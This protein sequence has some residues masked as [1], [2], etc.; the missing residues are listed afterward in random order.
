[1]NLWEMQLAT[2]AIRRVTEDDAIDNDPAFSADGK[3]LL[4]SS[5]R[6]GVFEIYIANRDGSEARQITHDGVDAENATMT[7][8]GKWVVYASAHPQKLGIWKI[9]PDGSGA[10][11]LV[12]GIVSNPEVSPDGVYVAYITSVQPEWAAI[13]IARVADGSEIPFQ[14]RCPIRKQNNIIIGRVRWIAA[15]QNGAADSLAYIGQDENGATGVFIQAFAPG[16]QKTTARKQLRR[17]DFR[18]P[19][20]SL[21][22]SPDG[23]TFVVSVAD[24]TT[25]VMLAKGVPGLNARR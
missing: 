8:D 22:I 13:K 6:S 18:M 19:V 23:K 16:T 20:E 25:S 4:F 10:I 5:D 11:R 17:F 3:R 14:I 12:K 1:M 2:G 15:S 7:R 24:D 9:H 21:G